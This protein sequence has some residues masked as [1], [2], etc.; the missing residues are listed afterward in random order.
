MGV[1]DF[2]PASCVIGIDVGGT[3][4]AGGAIVLPAG[5]LLCRRL[6]PTLPDRGGEAVLADV[7]ALAE[8][9]GAEARLLGKSPL[10]IGVGVAELVDPEGRIQSEATIPWKGQSISARIQAATRLPTRLDADV[11]AAARAEAWLGSGRGLCSF[12]YVTVGTGI[13]ASLVINGVPYLGAR[14]LT[15]TFASSQELIPGDD[16][17]L[18]TGPPLEQFSAG[19]ALARRFSALRPG[20]S[21][22]APDVVAL[23]ES[24]DTE[25]RSIVATAG[26]AVG[27]AIAQLVNVLDPEA[28]VLGG[29]LGL[30][31]G[32]FRQSIGQA[33]REHLYSEQHRD[34]PLFSARLKADAGWIGAALCAPHRPETTGEERHASTSRFP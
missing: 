30:V 22:T 9:L 15:G 13:S 3:K 25:A 6:Q 12:L 21:G 19:P 28:V 16:G 14:G 5:S 8:A 32:L 33:L 26:Q 11:R 7:I 20:F 4:C 18:Q 34:I 17:G 2:E 27:G 24:G 1:Q 10:A 29:G 23:A 31:E